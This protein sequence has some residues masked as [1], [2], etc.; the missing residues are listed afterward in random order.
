MKKLLIVTLLCAVD[1]NEGIAWGF[2]AHKKITHFATFLLPPDLA[3]FYKKHREAITRQSVNPDKRRYVIPEEGPRHYIDLENYESTFNRNKPLSYRAAVA[4]FS[5]DSL[6][7]FG[8]VPW[9]IIITKNRLIR[10]MRNR[11]SKKIIKY[12]AE[13]SHYIADSNVPLHTTENYN[14]QLTGQ[15]GIHGLWES[16]LPE[17]YSED[18]DLLIGGA[19]YVQDPL[20]RVW[21]TMWA[22]HDLVDRVLHLE[23]KL[24]N[25]FGPEKKYS[26]ELR[27]KTLIK[28]FSRDF[29]SQYRQG[30]NGQVEARFRTSIK[31]VADFWY[32]SW[33][34]A[35]QPVLSTIK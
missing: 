4:I 25:E 19:D 35:G 27:N 32:T 15:K 7:A 23:K 9:Q 16:R 8:I 18:Y 20:L 12:S 26:Y 30:L 24:T 3:V 21:E 29:C 22:S 10:A 14:G 28:T 1:L 31:M 2:F 11:D 17:L 13:L 34:E 6:M 33:I 5:E